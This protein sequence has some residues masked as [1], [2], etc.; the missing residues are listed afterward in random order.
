MSVEFRNRICLYLRTKRTVPD[1]Q[2]S[3]FLRHFLVHAPF[4][5]LNHFTAMMSYA[6]T[7]SKSAESETVF[8]LF[9]FFFFFF[10]LHWDQCERIVI[11]THSTE[12]S[13]AL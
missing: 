9:F 6:I 4:C 3:I 11:K 12:S 2:G 8:V 1:I 7:T 13:Y 5:T 10:F